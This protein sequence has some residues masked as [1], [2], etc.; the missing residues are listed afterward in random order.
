M[1]LLARQELAESFWPFAA[2]Q[3][4]FGFLP[5]LFRAQA[6]LPRVIEAEARIAGAV[7]LRESGLTRAQKERLLLALAAANANTYCVTAHSEILRRLGS[8]E[9]EI[10]QIV[11]EPGKARLAPVERALLEF[12]LKL[13]RAPGSIGDEDYQGLRELGPS[14]EVIL[15]AV[16]IAALTNFLCTL[17]LGLGAEPDFAPKPIPRRPDGSRP[18]FRR[19]RRESRPYLSFLERSAEDFPAFAF[20][21]EK[22]GFIPNLFRAQTLRPDIVEAEAQVVDAVL[23]TED[24]LTRFQKECILLVV[25]AANFNTYCVAVHCEMLRALGVAPETSD[26]VA[27]DHHQAGLSE[28]D[29]ALLDAALKLVRRPDEWGPLDVERLRTHGFSDPQI[30]EGVVM[31]ALTQ[32][33]NTL[34]TGLG[35]TPDFTPRLVFEKEN[36]SPPESSLTSEVESTADEDAPLVARV[37]QGD[38]GSFAELVRRHSGRL[39]RAVVGLTGNV[40]EAEDEVQNAFLK[41]FTHIQGFRGSARFST[42]LT[43][44]AINEVLDRLRERK[45]TASWVSL[46]ERGPGEEE[47]DFEPRNVQAWAS[48]PEQVYSRAETR[49][50]VERELMRLPV[51]YRVVILLRDIEQLPGDEVA[52]ALGLPLATMKTRL[53]RGRMMLREALAPHFVGRGKSAHA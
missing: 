32:F 21:Q 49:R 17:S 25:S 28:A 5:N 31:T 13:G 8:P 3:K 43:R 46:D 22:F 16:L 11:A 40:E 6:L 9:A 23:L 44:I 1:S 41:A 53:F 27:I 34:Q 35:T 19:H 24:V 51:K 52:A 30:L 14:D 38:A 50:L 4:E 47:V 36:L 42:W 7:L 15:E 29:T 48:D 26:Q 12:V 33:L 2:F 10:G 18:A 20:L 45:A 39:Y 37:Q